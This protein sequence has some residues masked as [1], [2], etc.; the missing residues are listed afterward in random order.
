MRA[1]GKIKF[2][3]AFAVLI[4]AGVVMPAEEALPLPPEWT[5]AQFRADQKGFYQA[6]LTY[7]RMVPEIF[8]EL[9][10]E[11]SHYPP[12]GLSSIKLYEGRGFA[13][14]RFHLGSDYRHYSR[15]ITSTEL[16]KELGVVE[17]DFRPVSEVQIY[18]GLDG[19]EITGAYFKAGEK[20]SISEPLT[21]DSAILF[22]GFSYTAIP[23]ETYGLSTGFF[24]SPGTTY[25][26]SA[27]VL[28]AMDNH[29]YGVQAG[30]FFAGSSEVNGIQIGGLFSYSR[31]LNGLQVGGLL[32]A[33][34]TSDF[35]G[36]QVGL[37][38]YNGRI[39]LPLIN[40]VY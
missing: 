21:A 19:I 40:L 12:Q 10:K 33:A 24:G 17:A 34:T 29:V 3:F 13:P 31:K 32:N 14:V 8:D 36:I 15:P 20:D 22:I 28:F 6:W 25:G 37:L 18:Y 5:Y 23:I 7:L 2:L 27:S 26:L 11:R 38:N 39:W 1:I 9:D 4:I 35:F 16:L 30:G